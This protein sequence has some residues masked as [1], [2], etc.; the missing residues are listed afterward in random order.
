[1]SILD[2]G[3]RQTQPVKALP[4]IYGYLVNKEAGPPLVVAMLATSLQLRKSDDDSN[5]TQSFVS[6]RIIS[7]R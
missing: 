2:C 7:P 6:G 5:V 1:L 3:P 4:H